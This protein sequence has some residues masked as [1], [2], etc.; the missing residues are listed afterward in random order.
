MISVVILHS[1]PSFSISSSALLKPLS[2]VLAYQNTI[3]VTPTKTNKKGIQTYAHSSLT[4]YRKLY[5]VMNSIDVHNISPILPLEC[6][7]P[8]KRMFSSHVSPSD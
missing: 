6:N 5:K 8:I 2:P 3:A 1:A 7:S 4:M